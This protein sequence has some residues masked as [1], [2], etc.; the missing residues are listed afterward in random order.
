VQ[1]FKV[2]EPSKTI[3]YDAIL[4]PD[5]CTLGHVPSLSVITCFLSY[6]VGK[7]VFIYYQQIE[8]HRYDSYVQPFTTE[9]PLKT[10]F[11]MM[12]LR[13]LTSLGKVM[14]L[15]CLSIHDLYPV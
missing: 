4:V 15:H 8:K 2:E 6:L 7:P 10:I 13:F 5:L 1:S 9:E 3:L 14:Y 11:G 12:S